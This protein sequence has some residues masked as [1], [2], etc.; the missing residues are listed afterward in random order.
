MLASI[1]WREAP[2]TQGEPGD[3]N[4]AEALVPS[5]CRSGWALDTSAP[6][7]HRVVDRPPIA[8]EGSHLAILGQIA[9]IGNSAD[10]GFLI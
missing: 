2:K 7:T 3:P 1:V 10:S 8:P 9:R 6:T 5:A 4:I